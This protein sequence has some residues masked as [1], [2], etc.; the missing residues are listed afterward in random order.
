MVCT[1]ALTFQ[2]FSRS[3]CRTGMRRSGKTSSAHRRR[4]GTL[5][6]SLSVYN[7]QIGICT[8]SHLSLLLALSPSLSLARSLALVLS[9]FLSFSLSSAPSALAQQQ[10]D[11]RGSANLPPGTNWE[12]YQSTYPSQ[13]SSTQQPIGAFFLFFL[14]RLS[15][16][17]SYLHVG[18]YHLRRQLLFICEILI[19]PATKCAFFLFC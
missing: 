13:P 4:R 2:N 10:P 15:I 11:M 7:R 18:S 16:L 9:L 5:S 17:L 19:Q 8:R 3:G 12:G 1:R 6:L 14:L